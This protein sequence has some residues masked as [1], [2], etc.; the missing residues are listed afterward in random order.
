MNQGGYLLINH[1]H[2]YLKCD[3]PTQ[4]SYVRD[5]EERLK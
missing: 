4:F 5:S 1:V 2:G 3:I